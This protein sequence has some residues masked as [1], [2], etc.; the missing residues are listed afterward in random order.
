MI[1]SAAVSPDNR[2]LMITDMGGATMWDV[3]TGDEIREFQ[4]HTDY[5]IIRAFAKDGG[6]LVTAR[7]G[8]TIRIWDLATVR[9]SVEDSDLYR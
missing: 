9:S 8:G 5:V 7:W 6:N 4:G 1:Y 3:E 2:T